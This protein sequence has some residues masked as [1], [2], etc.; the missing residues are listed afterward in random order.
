MQ[1]APRVIG[2]FSYRKDSDAKTGADLNGKTV[3][4]IGFAR[5]ESVFPQRRGSIKN[6][7]DS[8]TVKFVEVPVGANGTGAHATSCRRC[9]RPGNRFLNAARANAREIGKRAGARSE[10]RYVLLGWLAQDAWIAKKRTPP[11][12]A[13]AAAMRQAA[14]WGNK[15]P[16]ESA[17]ILLRY[18]KLSPERRENDDPF[19]L[20]SDPAHRADAAT[21]DRRCREIRYPREV[22]SPVQI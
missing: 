10:T 17:A 8:K 5:R 15:H 3:A 9:A 19:G 18:T 7:G 21:A 2:K 6:G 1:G 4:V 11:V 14:D 22:V 16:D 12:R 13:Y 20:R